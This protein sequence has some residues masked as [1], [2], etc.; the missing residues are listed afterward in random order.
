MYATMLLGRR[1]DESARSLHRQGNIAFYISG[2]GQEAAQVGAAFA[3]GCG[4]NWVVPYYRDMALMLAFSN[5]P[6]DFMLGLMGKKGEP[7]SDAR[8]MPGHWSLRKAKIVSHSSPVGRQTSNASG[9]VLMIKQRG[10]DQVVLT[11]IGE[12]DTS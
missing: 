1:L 7:T 4:K 3:L 2:I 5:Y 12:G 11:S 10:E 9:V 6:R 8:Q